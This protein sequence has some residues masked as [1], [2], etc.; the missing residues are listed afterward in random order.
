MG[1]RQMELAV[2]KEQTNLILQHHFAEYS[3]LGVTQCGSV[4]CHLW[5]G[6]LL[7]FL[8]V[9]LCGPQN[10]VAQVIAVLRENPPHR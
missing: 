7:A 8:L 2:G 9:R 3:C 10:D 6:S 5:L 4:R 1:G